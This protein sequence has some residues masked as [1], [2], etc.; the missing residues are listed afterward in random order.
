M[1]TYSTGS[2]TASGQYIPD[3]Q[4]T[5]DAQTHLAAQTT[6]TQAL[7]SLYFFFSAATIRAALLTVLY[8]IR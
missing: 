4:S 2:G 3:R 5:G 7:N 1:G 8:T 6:K